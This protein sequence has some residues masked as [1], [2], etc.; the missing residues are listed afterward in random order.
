MK[1]YSREHERGQA[2]IAELEKRRHTCEA[3]MAAMSACWEQVR[4][5]VG[6]PIRVFNLI[7]V[8]YCYTDFG[9]A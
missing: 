8:G 9:A 1:Y 5:R 3:G 2:Q 7:I 6:H 4:R